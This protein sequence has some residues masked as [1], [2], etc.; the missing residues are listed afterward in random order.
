MGNN[1][2]AWGRLEGGLCCLHFGG[3]ACCS[4]LSFPGSSDGKESPCNAGDPGSSPGSGRSSGERNGNSFQYSCL[5]NPMDGNSWQATVRGVTK[6]RTQLSDFTFT[7]C[8]DLPVCILTSS[9]QPPRCPAFLQHLPMS[10]VL[11]SDIPLNTTY[12]E[13]SLR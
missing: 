11:I 3:F 8:P 4:D 2:S 10:W 9:L 13:M 6:S 1:L 5:D 12:Q 7:F